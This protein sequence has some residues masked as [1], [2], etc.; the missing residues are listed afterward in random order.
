MATLE[1]LCKSKN[2]F[3]S[4][5]VQQF[6]LRGGNPAIKF[7]ASFSRDQMERLAMDLD[8]SR[9][10]VLGMSMH[11]WIDPDFLACCAVKI[12]DPSQR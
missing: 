5:P 9:S 8:V 6:F 11:N 12:S 7:R 3:A 10:V 2:L 1:V 4:E